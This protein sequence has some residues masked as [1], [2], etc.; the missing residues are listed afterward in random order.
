MFA[1]S[2]M[3]TP[4]WM[5]EYARVLFGEFS[6][7]GFSS[8]KSLESNLPELVKRLTQCWCKYNMRALELLPPDRSL[9]IKTNELSDRVEELAKF[10][11]VPLNS[12]THADR[13]NVSSDTSNLLKNFSRDELEEQCR[14]Y[15]AD[16][17]VRLFHE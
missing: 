9:I 3:E 8:R 12:L 15:G 1:E 6:W 2:G 17:L 11:G 4:F 13:V 7:D 10:I 14:K 5:E 16:S